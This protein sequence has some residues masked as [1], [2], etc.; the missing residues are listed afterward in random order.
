MIRHGQYY[1][2]YYYSTITFPLLDWLVTIFICFIDAT[3]LLCLFICPSYI[4]A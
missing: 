2:M 4:V 1:C 3:V